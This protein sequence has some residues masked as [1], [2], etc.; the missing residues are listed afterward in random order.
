MLSAEE[1]PGCSRELARAV[2]AALEDL[3]GQ[4]GRAQ[5]V[6]FESPCSPGRVAHEPGK[7]LELRPVDIPSHARRRTVGSIAVCV[8]GALHA[9]SLLVVTDQ[10][11]LEIYYPQRDVPVVN[12]RTADAFPVSLLKESDVS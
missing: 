5:V 11:T 8:V 10:R 7:T 3:A 1:A 12:A 9:T 2:E 6:L 4:A